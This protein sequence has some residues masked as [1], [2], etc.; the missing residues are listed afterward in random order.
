MARV[1]LSHFSPV[2][3]QG[4]FQSLVY[5]DAL[6]SA[7]VA[8]G[9]VVK[10]MIS[11]EFLD[12][13]WNGTN[14]LKSTLDKDKLVKEI[15]E[16]SPELCI[17]FNNS[18]PRCITDVLTC[19]ITLWH[20]DSFF[21]FNDREEIKK[22]IERFYFVCPFEDTANFLRH[23]L[24]VAEDKILSILPGTGIQKDDVLQNK[25]ISFIG[26]PFVSGY[27]FLDYIKNNDKTAIRRV[28]DRLLKGDNTHYQQMTNDEGCSDL[29]EKVSLSEMASLYSSES[30][31]LTL[32]LISHM[33]LEIYG[34]S[35]WYD[36]G[37]Y[38]PW[39]A[40]A[41]N[42][43]KVYSL[44][45]NLDIYNSSKICLNVSHTQATFG[46]PWRIMDIMASNGCLVSDK[47]IGIQKFTKGYVDIPVYESP[48]E[49]FELCKK[50]LKDEHWLSLIHI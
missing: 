39:I 45:H 31:M 12:K 23:E 28:A 47:N 49:A 36:I 32:G 25:N 15:Q 48:S 38:M 14:E 20:A 11:S 44:K 35:Q 41:Y 5:Y 33:G 30:R 16:F 6:V 34:G 37:L 27:S 22:N 2:L 4:Q 3:D 21:Y 10:H 13:P 50:I 40:M 18:I 17:A 19:S 43:Q 26:T 29:A 24:K 7:L 1:L 46:F 9:N 42:P 8:N